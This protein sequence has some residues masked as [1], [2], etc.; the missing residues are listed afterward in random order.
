VVENF[1]ARVLAKNNLAYEDVIKVKPDIIFVSASGLGRTGP[2]RDVLAYGSLLQAY[3]GRVNLMGRLNPELEGMG[4][5]P[6]WT[7]PVT[8]LWETLAIQAALKHREATGEGCYVDLSMLEATVALLPDAILRASLGQPSGERGSESELGASPSGCFRCN[9]DDDW[10]AL[11]IRS[12]PEWAALCRAMRR[13]DLAERPSLATVEGRRAVKA[14]LDH[15][16]AIW[17]LRRSAAEC[18]AHLQAHGVPA[19]RTRGIYDLVKDRHVAERGI[20]RRLEDGSWTTTLPW[21]DADGW[22]GAFAPTPKLGAHNDYVFGEILKVSRAK[23]D[24][25]KEMGVIR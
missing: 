13:P 20:F 7:D 16:V 19:A 15:E 23:Q 24:E 14:D 21:T 2:E 4:V 8:S 10:L 11:S 25:L 5:M 1:S 6:A 22:R 17:C 18:E 3:S 9:G 12:D